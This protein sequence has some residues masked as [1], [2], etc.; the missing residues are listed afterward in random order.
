MR[1]KNLCAGLW[2]RCWFLKSQPEVC[3]DSFG[4]PTSQCPVSAHCNQL[5]VNAKARAA[6]DV[7][8]QNFRFANT[9]FCEHTYTGSHLRRNSLQSHF[10]KCIYSWEWVRFQICTC[11]RTLCCKYMQYV[12]LNRFE[13]VYSCI[14]APKWNLYCNYDLPSC[15]I[16]QC[17]PCLLDMYNSLLLFCWANGCM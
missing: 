6:V 10:I 13:L 16:K 7:C 5:I 15:I 3:I 12:V 2:C 1:S 9:R 17:W 14:F 11:R 8:S 4:C